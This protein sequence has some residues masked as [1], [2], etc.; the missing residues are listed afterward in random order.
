MHITVWGVMKDEETVVD[1]LR[2]HQGIVW[3]SEPA[4]QAA[5]GNPT[6]SLAVQGRSRVMRMGMDDGDE[7]EDGAGLGKSEGDGEGLKTVAE[8]VGQHFEDH[9]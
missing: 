1:L 4:V 7:D 5:V 3:R 8:W 6:L 9:G 2:R